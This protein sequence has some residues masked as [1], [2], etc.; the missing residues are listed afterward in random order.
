MG[1]PPKWV[2][3][4]KKKKKKICFKFIS[5]CQKLEVQSQVPLARERNLKFKMENVVRPG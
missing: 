1:K 2:R 5:K 3:E 4:R